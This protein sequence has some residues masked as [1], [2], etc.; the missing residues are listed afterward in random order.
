MGKQTGE[1]QRFRDLL[2]AARRDRDISRAA[3][4]ILKA[5]SLV[6]QALER[7][8]STAG[9]TLPQFNILM[10]LAATPDAV[11]PLYEL[12]KR[13]ISTPP[14]TSF[15]CSRMEQAGL[16]TKSRDAR[17]SRVVNLALTEQGWAALG[18]AAP[19]AFAAER[20]L[21]GEFSREDLR[22]LGDLL[23]HLVAPR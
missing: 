1:P 21:L 11:L 17:D 12:N 16:V 6:G 19:V 20:E 5:D 8:L 13:L 22:R 23:T 15:L 2:R 4:A 3:V 7:A 10:E 18:A 9:L 14:N